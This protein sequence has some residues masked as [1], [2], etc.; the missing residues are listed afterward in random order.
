MQDEHLRCARPGPALNH[1]PYN[2]QR[3]VFALISAGNNMSPTRLLVTRKYAIMIIYKAVDHINL[4]LTLPNANHYIVID[5]LCAR[6]SK[7]VDQKYRCSLYYTSRRFD[8]STYG[9]RI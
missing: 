3:R 2:D 6:A 5:P 9:A 4:E 1:G 8:R 7:Y